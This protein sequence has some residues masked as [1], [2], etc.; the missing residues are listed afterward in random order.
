MLRQMG[1]DEL[2]QLYDKD[3]ILRVHNSKNL[4]DT[5]KILAQ[6]KDHLGEYPPSAELAKSFLSRYV[7]KK[8]RTLYRYAQ[9]V[10]MFMKWYGEPINDLKL[11]IPKSLPPYTADGEID[12]V[13]AAVEKCREV[14]NE[15]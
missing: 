5:R 8:P 14:L 1:N 12:R 2:F 13:F 6:F 11:R 4:G 10:R 9:M 3:L 15:S 7:N